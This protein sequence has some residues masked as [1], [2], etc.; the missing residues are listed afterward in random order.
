MVIHLVIGDRDESYLDKLQSY[1]EKNYY[2]EIETVVFTD[3]AFLPK[4]LQD[5]EVDVLLVD[6][7]FGDITQFSRET[8]FAVLSG[9]DGA[10]ADGLRTILK[11]KKPSLLYKDVINIYSGR[12][13]AEKSSSGSNKGSAESSHKT[14]VHCFISFSGGT[15]V[16]VI[17]AAAA[18]YFAKTSSVFYLNLDGFSSSTLFFKGE[19]SYGFDDILYALK[20]DAGSLELKLKSSVRKDKSGVEFLI[21]ASQPAYMLE[22]TNEDISVLIRTLK[23]MDVYD[24][25]V[26]DYGFRLDSSHK[27]I[28]AM[29]DLADTITIVSDGS[30][31][32]NDKFLRTMQTIEVLESEHKKS[33]LRKMGLLYN[34][35]SSSESSIK[36][37]RPGMRE[38]GTIIPIHH[39]DS[40]RV[41][42][43]IADNFGSC[44]RTL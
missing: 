10:R 18:K 20:G 25:I 1:F 23:S 35:F 29:L 19:G 17:S 22:L 33:V 13:D 31:T 27:S 2:S 28:F 6:E 21:P 24:R 39:A 32:A 30:M 5:N 15:G 36:M 40:K 41:M 11:Y 34:N 3:P 37:E 12:P 7:E 14:K 4:Y 8:G 38:I 26:I 42:S 9:S 43:Y 44:F 16:S